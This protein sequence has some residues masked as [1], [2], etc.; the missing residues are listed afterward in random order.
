VNAADVRRFASLGVIASMQPSHAVE[1]MPWAEA[2]IGPERITGAYAWRSLRRAGA[3]LVFNSDLPAT[4]YNIFYGLHSAVTRRD[5]H[6]APA[7]GWRT[8]ERM[9]IEE[10]VRGWTTWAAR[11][12]FQ[13]DNAGTIAAGGP[14]DLTVMDIDPFTTDPSR[15]L[16]GRI[17]LTIARG[18]AV[19]DRARI[20][21]SRDGSAARR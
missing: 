16:A 13:E 1:D 14:G 10:A 15:L 4:D 12:T 21:M 3:P 5:K 19:Y 18:T 7:G 8:E 6:N 20:A 11:A 9:T 17:V 2:R